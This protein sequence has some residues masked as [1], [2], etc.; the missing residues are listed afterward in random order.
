MYNTVEQAAQAW[1]RV[2]WVYRRQLS[3]L[4]FPHLVHEYDSEQSQATVRQLMGA[5]MALY[6][7]RGKAAEKA[8]EE[9]AKAAA[10]M[11]T[12]GLAGVGIP[13][14]EGPW[15]GGGSQTT[16]GAGLV[17]GGAEGGVTSKKVCTGAGLLHDCA[18]AKATP[19]DGTLFVHLSDQHCCNLS[20]AL[21]GDVACVCCTW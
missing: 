5:R 11:A 19:A 4:N 13:G 16:S 8:K 9:A 3:H 7:P 10:V 20:V 1:D 15:A 2:S 12:G 18:A 21:S 6:K 14:A 17:A